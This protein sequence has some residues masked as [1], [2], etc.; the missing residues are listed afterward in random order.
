M[1][2]K[3]LRKIRSDASWNRL[4]TEQQGILE[5]WLFEENVSFRQAL[6]RAKMEFAFEG[7]LSGLKRFYKRRVQAR[8][9][10]EVLRAAGK[11]VSA[12]KEVFASALVRLSSDTGG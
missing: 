1:T 12:D 8:W 5:R 7:S 3:L 4:T 10:V 2:N 11:L 6:A 9:L